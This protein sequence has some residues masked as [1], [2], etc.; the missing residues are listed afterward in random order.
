[1]VT[2]DPCHAMNPIQTYICVDM[3]KYVSGYTRFVLL[4]STY[5]NMNFVVFKNKHLY[6]APIIIY[7]IYRKS[8]SH[9][10]D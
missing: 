6:S 2:S 10:S 4:S 9:N 3:C 8:I 1:M 7:L 5:T